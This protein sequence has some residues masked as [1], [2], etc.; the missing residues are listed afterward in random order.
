MWGAAFTMIVLAT[1]P[2]AAQSVAPPG[3]AACSGC[4]PPAAVSGIV[5]PP[6]NGRAAADIV[7]AMNG[8]RTGQ[9]PA[10]VMDRLAKGFSDAEIQAMAAWFSAQR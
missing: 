10:T 1:A 9:L 3:T 8:F 5:V 4:H 2:A 6:L 7:T